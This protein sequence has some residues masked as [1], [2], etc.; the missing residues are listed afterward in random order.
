MVDK[1]QE[2][3]VRVAMTPWGRNITGCTSPDMRSNNSS[4]NTDGVNSTDDGIDNSSNNS[5]TV[6]YIPIGEVTM[7]LFD[8]HRTGTT[9]EC[10]HFCHTPMLWTPVFDGIYLALIQADPFSCG[11][12]LVPSRSRPRPVTPKQHDFSRSQQPLF[13][14]PSLGIGKYPYNRTADEAPLTSCCCTAEKCDTT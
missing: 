8:M 6:F 14:D 13:W 7:P 10:T 11:E 9:E 12:P 3:G 2:A 5:N 4:D 1:L